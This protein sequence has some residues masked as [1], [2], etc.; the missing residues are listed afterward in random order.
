MAIVFALVTVLAQSAQAQTYK[1]IHDFTGGND[2]QHPLATL[3]ADRAGNLYGSAWDTV[4]KMSNKGGGWVLT[5]LYIFP[6]GNGGAYPGDVVFGPD[7]SLYSTAGGGD[8]Y[9]NCGL[10]FNL[11]P[12]ASRPASL[13]SPW[14]ATVL[15]TFKGSPY[16]GAYPY[17]DALIFDS[18]GNLY[19]TTYAGGS[20]RLGVAYELTP[21]SNGWTETT[22]DN[23]SYP[24]N[25]PYSGVIMD[26][27]GNLFGT[28]GDGTVVFEL[29]PTPSG[30]VETVLHTFKRPDGYLAYGGLVM[31]TAGNLY[32]ATAVGGTYG[33]GVIYELSPS[34]GGWNYQILYNF[35]T[36]EGPYA[37][38]TLDAAGNLYGMTHGGGVNSAGSVFE[39]SPSNGSWTFTELHDFSFESEYFPQG[40]VT[41]DS[42]GNLFGMTS[43]GGA[44]GHGVVWEITP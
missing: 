27:A 28:T 44:Y 30:W 20:D 35:T 22:I 12:P 41:L 13:Y 17:G 16:D 33:S 7:G 40:G 5:P 11:K 31:D 32:G 8:P 9:C 21:S 36:G 25:G 18:A 34:S 24:T 43:A 3:T 6:G 37:S 26:S 39:F 1:V 23:F 15:Y 10:V 4:F 14:K 19:G 29:S 42:N 38:L 2:G